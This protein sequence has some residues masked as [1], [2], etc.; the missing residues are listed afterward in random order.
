MERLCY[1]TLEKSGYEGFL[2]KDAP[3]RVLQFGEGNFLRAFA[4]CFID[5]MN[6]KAG[7]NGKVITVTPRGSGR[8]CDTI[9]KQEG[10]YT[11]LIKGIEDGS[12]VT[13]ER[14]I[15]CV[16]G[17][18]NP[19]RD[20]EE[21]MSYASVPEL[22]FII[23]NTTEA[24]IVYDPL[25][26]N[27]DEPPSCFPAKLTKFLYARY[28]TH[29]P[30]FIILPCELIDRNGDELK[31]CVERYI[32][33]WELPDDFAGWVKKENVFCSTLVD[34]I[35]PG[36]PK[37][38]AAALCDGLGYADELLDMAEV[39][40][41]WVIEGPDHVRGAFPADKAGLPV[42]FV[43]NVDPYKKRKVRI[44]NGA[45]TSMSLAAYL[46]GKDIVRDCMADKVICAFM[47]TAVNDEIIPVL[48]DLDGDE[49]R[50][51]ADAVS[52]RFANPFIDHELLSI[53]LNSTSKW[54]ARVMPTVLEYH[55]LKKEL[56]VL[57]TFSFAAYLSFYHSGRELKDGA[58]KGM[59][60][61][62]EFLIKDDPWILEEFL[63]LK[64]SDERELAETII[65]NEKMWGSRLKDIPGFTKTVISDLKLINDKGMH[66]AMKLIQR[67]A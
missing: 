31:K 57:L 48:R 54:K 44:L 52:S 45:H 37:A 66:E 53:A 22:K 39:F 56:P 63:R 35:V 6:E 16:A 34:R 65:N 38:E 12:A 32:K 42:K 58:L 17:C 29:L 26:K 2:L 10:L 62:R 8:T 24:G 23:S 4:D 19:N 9:N 43:R 67:K 3:V 5:V 11:L 13:R 7:F 55:E 49:V 18:V 21:Y 1:S 33:L 59:R 51:F 27:D 14:V 60:D 46:A 20:H 61:G 40:A 30:G 64:D 15:S 28:K 36:Y 25:C 50:K 41:E 47:N